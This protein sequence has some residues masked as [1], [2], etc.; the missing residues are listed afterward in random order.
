[1]LEDR[2][3]DARVGGRQLVR[4]LGLGGGAG[5]V[6]DARL[7]ID[8]VVERRDQSLLRADAVVDGL[9]RH[10]RR[11]RDVAHAR[12]RVAALGEQ[13]PRG[14]QD[15]VSRQLCPA[16]TQAGRILGHDLTNIPVS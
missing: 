2:P 13:M 11:L 12:A 6:R 10:P 7:G 9:R 5:E 8:E 14:T 16:L 4:V 15:L 3:R 1:M